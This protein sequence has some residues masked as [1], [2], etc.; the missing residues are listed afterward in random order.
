MRR[1]WQRLGAALGMLVAAGCTTSQRW[2]L[3]A[4]GT[5]F[6]FEV[7]RVERRG[8]WLDVSLARDELRLRSF[9]P[10]SREC[11]DLLR[12]EAT[13]TWSQGGSGTFHSR[14]GGAEL[15]CRA[16]GI[17]SL[18]E[19]RDRVRATPGLEESIVPSAQADYRIVYRDEDVAFLRGRFPLA[20]RLGWTSLG[21]TIAVVPTGPD[22]CT[23]VLE[24]EVGT[25]EYFARGTP[26]LA[27]MGSGA[28]CPIVGLV[29]PGAP[30]GAEA[31][32]E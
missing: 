17:G 21:D 6:D 3:G 15:R 9:V 29:R 31:R 18:E 2:Q 19:W 22:A 28:R 10:A 32:V 16:A 30:P 11:A 1:T 14:G 25:M 4:P 20:S 8:D 12:P 13:V 7:T 23:D 27:L 26:V 24:R 5:S